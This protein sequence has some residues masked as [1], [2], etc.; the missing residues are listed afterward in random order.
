[1]HA[2]RY[3]TRLLLVALALGVCA[4]QLF[5]GRALGIS[6]P[7][8]VVL[9]LAALASLGAAEERAPTRANLWLGASALFFALCV[10]WRT[11][12]ALMVFNVLAVF[13]LLLL[14]VANYRGVALE[15][16]PGARALAQ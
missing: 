3:P 2:L 5:Y 15:R 6:A 13:G 16:L 1:M 14:L 12:P 7:L 10:A 4:D 8:F 9:G 11:A